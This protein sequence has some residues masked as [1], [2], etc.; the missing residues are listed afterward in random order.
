MFTLLAMGTRNLQYGRCCFI[1]GTDGHLFDERL[2]VVLDGESIVVVEL[3]VELF[4][5]PHPVACSVDQGFT[6]LSACLAG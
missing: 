2:G 6:T 1:N 3:C 4:D 5:T